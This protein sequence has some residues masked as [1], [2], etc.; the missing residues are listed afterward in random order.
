MAVVQHSFALVLVP[1]PD[2][3]HLLVHMNA[4]QKPPYSVEKCMQAAIAMWQL[5]VQLAVRAPTSGSPA[6]SAA[7]CSLLSGVVAPVLQILLLT[8]PTAHD[9][10]GGQTSC[11]LPQV[12][13]FIFAIEKPKCSS[14]KVFWNLV[15]KVNALFFCLC[16]MLCAKA[17]ATVEA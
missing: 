12:S 4:S 15:C 8:T 1:V 11:L 16:L 9:K 13:V 6:S 2:S 7:K 3:C 14:R 5:M 17:C 10:Q